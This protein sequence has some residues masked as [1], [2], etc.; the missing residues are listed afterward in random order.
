[1]RLH[2]KL[3]ACL[4]LFASIETVAQHKPSSETAKYRL[5]LIGDAGK[6]G[7]NPSLKMLKSKLDA[8]N[9]QTGIIFLGDN[10]YEKGMPLKGSKNRNEAEQII[11]SQINTVGDF[12]GDIFFIPGNHDWNNGNN[13]GWQRLR[14]QENYIENKLDSA[15]VFFPSNGCPGPIEVP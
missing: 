1:M 12:K 11:D 10:I 13:D 4:F 15:N 3:L 14:E 7:G 2:L 9:N 6:A 8:A 5:Y